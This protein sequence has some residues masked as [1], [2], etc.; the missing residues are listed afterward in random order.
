MINL[1]IFIQNVLKKHFAKWF[2][3]KCKKGLQ[4]SYHISKK[5]NI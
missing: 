5:Q 3:T 2:M 4:K 1:Q